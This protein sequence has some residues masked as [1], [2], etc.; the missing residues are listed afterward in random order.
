MEEMLHIGELKSLSETLSVSKQI[1]NK[2]EGFTHQN[3]TQDNKQP[4]VK[5]VYNQPL[6]K[7]VHK[8]PKKIDYSKSK[9]PKAII[10]AITKDDTYDYYDSA[11]ELYQNIN[12]TKYNET[13]SEYK[14]NENNNVNIDYK[15]IEYL[16][17]KCLDEKLKEITKINENNGVKQLRIKEDGDIRFVTDDGSVYDA[18]LEYKGKTKKKNL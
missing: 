17:N 4:L 12:P 11:Q 13:S 5:E 9:L 16:I 6:V 2:V 8:Q 10:E 1:M 7:E 14:P 3:K 15:Y 18:K